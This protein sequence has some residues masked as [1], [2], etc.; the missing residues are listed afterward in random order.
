[1]PL[2]L[3]SKLVANVA[4]VYCRG[5]IVTGEESRAL[6]Q[7]QARL[8]IETPNVVLDMSEVDFVDSGGLGALVRMLGSLRAARGDLKICRLRPTLLKVF[9]VTH[10]H[11]VFEMYESEG[12][13]LE[14]FR[15]RPAPREQAGQLAKKKVLCVDQ[16]VDLLAYLKALLGRQGYDVQTTHI[17]SD[18]RT[19]LVATSPQVVVAGHAMQ[20]NERVAEALRTA[21]RNVP[22]LFLPAEFSTAEASQAGVELLERLRVLFANHR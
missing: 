11:T 7:E 3:Q 2:Q 12:E 6:Q 18:F 4:V 21:A 17:P 14:A 9:Q 20:A 15:R 1:M 13:A 10:L 19:I 8:T 5:R 22:V 16:S